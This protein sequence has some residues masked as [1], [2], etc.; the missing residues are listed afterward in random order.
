MLEL[1]NLRSCAQHSEAKQTEKLEL[2]T[3]KGLL[4]SLGRRTGGSCSKDL[5]SPM[6]FREVFLKVRAGSDRVCESKDCGCW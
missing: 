4:C 5:N 1:S 3:E 2:G 6:G